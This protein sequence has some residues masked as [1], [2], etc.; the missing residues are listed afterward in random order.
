MIPPIRV[1]KNRTEYTVPI[2]RPNLWGNPFAIG[3]SGTRE[4]VLDSFRDYIKVHFSD[5]EL[6]TLENQVLGCVCKVHQKCHG[7]IIIEEFNRRF[8]Q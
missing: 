8:N 1:D 4:E 2:T 3:W 5:E 7:D 6:A